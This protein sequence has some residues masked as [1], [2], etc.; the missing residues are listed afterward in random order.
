MGSRQAAACVAASRESHPSAGLTEP[1]P[2]RE[3]WLDGSIIVI[4][5]VMAMPVAIRCRAGDLARVFQLVI[6]KT[7]MAYRAASAHALAHRQE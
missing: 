7:V 2:L 5:T 1:P 4:L 3:L 6:W